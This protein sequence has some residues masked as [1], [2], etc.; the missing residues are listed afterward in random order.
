MIVSGNTKMKILKWVSL[1]AIAGLLFVSSA[2]AAVYTFNDY[3]APGQSDS[4]FLIYNG[5]AIV[6]DIINLTSTV[7]LSMLMEAWNFNTQQGDDGFDPFQIE[8]WTGHNMGGTLLD[9]VTLSPGQYDSGTS[10]APAGVYSFHITGTTLPDG[11]TY[12]IQLTSAAVPLP[13]AFWLFGSALVAF[14]GFGRR[15]AA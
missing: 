10:F 5:G 14:I 1:A 6:N 9:T 7:D 2:N 4:V 13:A 8:L 3:T 11:G 12:R 15:S